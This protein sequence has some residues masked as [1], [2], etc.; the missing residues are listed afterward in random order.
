MVA[1]FI[2]ISLGEKKI[3]KPVDINMIIPPKVQKWLD[4]GIFPQRVM[5]SGAVGVLDTAL[6]VAAQLQNVSITEIEKGLHADTSIFRD[7]G[8]SFKIGDNSDDY[9]SVRGLIKWSN[10]KPTAPKRII[11]L[12][13]IERASREA[14]QALLKLIEE[15]PPSSVFLFTTRNHHQILDTIISRMTVLRVSH[16][17][18]DFEISDEVREFIFGKDIIAK[19][20][21]IDELIA[22]S[23]EEKTGKQPVLDFLH[24]LILQARLFDEHRVHLSDI[25]ETY[26][27]VR[28]NTNQKLSLERLALKFS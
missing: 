7:D 14:P 25:F 21:K 18:E 13:N 11:I 23:K 28:G 5:L 3:L 9:E 19:F 12:E 6:E 2:G 8:T 24:E 22:T 1:D 27:A 15:P 26:Q 4:K 20:Q 16:S 17:T 10:Q